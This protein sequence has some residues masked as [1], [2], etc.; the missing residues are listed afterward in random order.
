MPIMMTAPVTYQVFDNDPNSSL[1][2]ELIAA[3]VVKKITFS[4]SGSTCADL[5]YGSDRCENRVI[6]T[7]NRPE[8]VSF[9]YTVEFGPGLA[10]IVSETANLS[11]YEHQEMLVDDSCEDYDLNASTF[12]VGAIS[13]N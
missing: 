8:N 1:F 5:G 6:L 4:Y 9:P 2:G 11:A 12:D 7:S 10:W 13:Y 3:I